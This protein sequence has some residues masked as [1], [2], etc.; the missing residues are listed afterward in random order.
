MLYRGRNRGWPLGQD[1]GPNKY[2][3]LHLSRKNIFNYSTIEDIID[4]IF[5]DKVEHKIEE[6]DIRQMDAKSRLDD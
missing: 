5:T 3:V 6:K 2:K 1:R 4:N